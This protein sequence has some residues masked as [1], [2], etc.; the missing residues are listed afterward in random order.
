MN[1]GDMEIVRYEE[2]LRETEKA[3]N[4]RFPD[5]V[6]EWLPKSQTRII[7]G[8]LYATKWIIGQKAIEDYVEKR[9]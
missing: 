2:I 1:V 3:R 5:G 8:T 6:V 4:I 9:Q 7:D